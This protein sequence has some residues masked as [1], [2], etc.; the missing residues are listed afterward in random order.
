MP[1]YVNSDHEFHDVIAMKNKKAEL[2]QRERAT[3][4]HV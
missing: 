1:A 4:V 2:T 3:A